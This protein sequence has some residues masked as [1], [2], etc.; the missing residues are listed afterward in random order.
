MN[1]VGDHGDA[2]A[3]FAALVAANP[4]A[5]VVGESPALAGS[6]ANNLAA[7]EAAAEDEIDRYIAANPGAT[8]LRGPFGSA[9]QPQGS[10]NTWRFSEDLPPERRAELESFVAMNGGMTDTA[11]EDTAAADTAF[12]EMVAAH[13]GA[14]EVA[15]GVFAVVE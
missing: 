14:R 2:E 5:R 7:H 9:A 3:A 11:G 10:Q 12:A 1:A 4:G 13:P 8:V 15:P 6:H